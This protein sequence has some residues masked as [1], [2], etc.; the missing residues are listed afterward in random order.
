MAHN[1]YIK[2][3]T[4]DGKFIKGENTEIGSDV[5]DFV[6]CFETHSSVMIPT[7]TQSGKANGARFYDPT[8]AI[9][10]VGPQSPE[11][12]K[13]LTSGEKLDITHKFYR[14]ENGVQVGFFE[15][16]YKNATLC[17]EEVIL[18]DTTNRENAETPL[19]SK[20]FWRFEE[21]TM[22]YTQGNIEHTDSLSA[23]S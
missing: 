12:F 6:R 9:V 17:G 10:E 18:R 20:L 22:T 15:M 2:F 11:L 23:Q 4:V 16:V 7:D 5:S 21:K 19:L 1:S 13:C 3:E 14:I 8:W